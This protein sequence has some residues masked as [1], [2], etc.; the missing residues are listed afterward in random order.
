MQNRP[1]RKTKQEIRNKKDADILTQLLSGNDNNLKIKVV[2]IEGKGRG[3]IADCDF[4]KGYFIVEYAGDLISLK[5][6]KLR[7]AKYAK[8]N[9]LGGFIYYFR[10]HEIPLCVDATPETNRIG[11]PFELFCKGD[12][13]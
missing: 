2:T 7:E 10:S 5:E 13:K 9:K 8:E 4:E 12:Q 11:K 1:K 6:G 3:V